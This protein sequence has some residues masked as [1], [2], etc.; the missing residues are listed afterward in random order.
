MFFR[1]IRELYR[2]RRQRY[3]TV[4]RTG[5]CRSALSKGTAVK[6]MA[7]RRLGQIGLEAQ[8]RHRQMLHQLQLAVF[9][10]AVADYRGGIKARHFDMV[11][12]LSS[13]LGDIP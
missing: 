2:W 12:R 13:V 10:L 5:V 7:K 8:G 1:H 11:G 6:I 4:L 9:V 3:Q